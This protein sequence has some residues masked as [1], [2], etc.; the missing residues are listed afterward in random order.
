MNLL[1]LLDE[2]VELRDPLQREVV[3]QI[4]FI[5]VLRCAAPAVQSII[6]ARPRARARAR[7]SHLNVLFF[8]ILHSHRECG[9]EQANLSFRVAVVDELLHERLELRRQQLVSLSS[10]A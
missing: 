6:A 4:D 5:G 2:D 7:A 3:H 9:R 1:P 8:E 10:G